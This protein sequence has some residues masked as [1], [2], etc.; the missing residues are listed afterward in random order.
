LAAGLL[1]TSQQV[2]AALGISLASV[3]AT[4]FALAS[5]GAPPV[6][7]TTGY[8]AALYLALGLSVIAITLAVLATRTQI[9]VDMRTSTSVVRNNR[10]EQHVRL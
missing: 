6:A 1:N 4:S 3:V 2:G 5:G 7:T 10:T 8:Q 9:P